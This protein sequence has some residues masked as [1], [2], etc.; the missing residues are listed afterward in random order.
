[1][2]LYLWFTAW[3]KSRFIAIVPLGNAAL[4]E[5]RRV[6]M[7][8]RHR[9]ALRGTLAAA[10]ATFV[11]LT[12]PILG[13]GA[14]PSAT[15]IIVPLTLS[16]L[17]CV[18]VSG[19]RLSLP[20]P[21]ISVGIS[22]TLFHLLFSLFTPIASG[23]L[24]GSAGLPAST[25]SGG[26]LAA[27]LGSHSQHASMHSTHHAPMHSMPSGAMQRTHDSAVMPAMDGSVGAA[28]EMHSHSSP[29]MLLAHCIAGI[30]TIAM[31]SWAE[32]L[33]IMLGEFAR[34][35]IRAVIPRLVVLRAPIEKPRSLTGYEP[36]LPRSLGVCRSPVL[37]RGPPQPAF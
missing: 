14:F 31:I 19:R 1:M 35:I 11:A 16:T 23:A 10:A 3:C 20:R 24:P 27:L 5:N 33:P 7:R 29:A 18:L 37:R 13:G 28:A 2:V 12:S 22:Q 36:E 17:V 26:G 6:G 15:G 8:G 34:L 21:T 30:I 32:R 4:C 25:Q 9:R